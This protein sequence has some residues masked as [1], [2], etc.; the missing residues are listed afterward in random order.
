[1]LLSACEIR[2]LAQIDWGSISSLNGLKRSIKFLEKNE[3]IKIIVI[4]LLKIRSVF[5]FQTGY[6]IDPQPHTFL[7]VR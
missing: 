2:D 4:I 5:L 1:M 7:L 6:G 3:S